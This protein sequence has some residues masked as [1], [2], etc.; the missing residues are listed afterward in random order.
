[1][2]SWQAVLR[3]AGGAL[4]LLAG[5]S[6]ARPDAEAAP[7]EAAAA[8]VALSADGH[9][10]AW[11]VSSAF[12]HPRGA[13]EAHL[14]PHLGPHWKL[15]AANDGPLDVAAATGTHS[16]DRYAYAGGVLHVEHAG[17]HLLLLAVD[18]G[19]TVIL[20]GARVFSRDEG[21]PQRED[22]DLVPVDLSA[23]DHTLVL[24]LHQHTGVWTFRA[25]ILDSTLEA[26]KGAFWALPGTTD[27]D[28]ARLASELARVSLH[29]DVADDGYRLKLGVRYPE[30][31]PR[32]VKLEVTARLARAP[33]TS[34]AGD[35][36]FDV[37]AGEVP[38]V[39]QAMQLADGGP[40]LTVALPRVAGEEVEDGD[41]NVHVTVAGRAFDLPFSPRKAVRAAILRADRALVSHGDESVAHLRDRLTA[42]VAKGDSDLDAQA[43]DAREL[44][45]LARALEEGRDPW[46]GRTGPMRRAYLSPADGKLSEFALY[47][48]PGFDPQRTYPLIVA[49]H[50]MNGHP[51]QM[52]MWLFGHDDP[53]RDGAWEDRHPLHD[54]ERL[55]AIVVAPG[56]HFNAMYREMG[57]DDVMR[58]TDWAMAHFPINP[59]RVS[60]T[61]PSMGGIGTAACALHHP[62]RF[63]A[64]APLCGY[65]RYFVRGDIG[66]AWMRPWE[67][68][69]AEQRSN[70]TGPRTASTCPCSSCTERRTCP[71]KTAACSS[72][73][74]TSSTTR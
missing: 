22:D 26:P 15:A 24:A 4:I 52:L 28:A 61:G 70:V 43:A 31:A 36:L 66:K 38:Q 64:A 3:G 60:I 41:W 55:D 47:V 62:D 32:G 40:E 25:R 72:T 12:E 44:D 56:G 46:A 39:R 7:V 63:A 59:A 37:N 9:I 54:L 16:A 68:F 19:V 48:P 73:G 1:M 69:M 18:D 29:R 20:D 30:G 57:E 42:F 53:L 2:R 74:T 67:R 17:R 49:L 11:L 14:A 8:S 58:V 34:D 35:P 33:S 27:A 13:D 5:E 45:E 23:G 10:G 51:M 6:T 71:R 65:H 50:G 21:R